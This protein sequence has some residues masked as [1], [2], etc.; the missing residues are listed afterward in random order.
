MKRGL[1][2][3]VFLLLVFLLACSSRPASS[4]TT[5]VVHYHRFDGNYE[6]WNLWIWPVEPIRGEG[7]AYQFTDLDDFGAKATVVL[8]MKLTKV[9]IIVRLR[10]WEAKDVDKDRFIDIKDGKAEVWI[11][12][13]VEEIF[14][15]RPNIGPSQDSDIEPSQDSDTEPYPVSD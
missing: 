9:G 8:P 5:I 2:F 7:K 13:G 4:E 15:E 6:G 14:Y 12:Q 3:L 10:E 1:F 11:I